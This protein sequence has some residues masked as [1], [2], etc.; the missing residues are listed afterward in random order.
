VTV[1]FRLHLP[2]LLPLL[3]GM[4]F[5]FLA[6]L[7]LPRAQAGLSREMASLQ[8]L[9]Q[10]LQQKPLK[11]LS[12]ASLWQAA[13][14]GMLA[15][16][17]DPYS[18]YLN[19]QE[20][21]EIK[22]LKTGEVAGIGIE[23]G[24]Q[25]GKLKVISALDHSPAW[26]AGLQAGDLIRKIEAKS[27]AQLS[28][29]ESLQLLQGEVQT[30]VQLEIERPPS[31]TPFSLRIQREILDLNPVRYQML[32]NQI[33]Y[34]RLNSF[35]SDQ[36]PES[37]QTALT[38]LDEADM[39]ALILDLRNNP[40]GTL[41]NAIEVCSLFLPQGNVVRVVDRENQET[42]H[43]VTGLPLLD[44]GKEL[45]L[46][47]NQ[48]TASA[49]E[50]VAGSLQEQGRAVLLGQ[51]TFGKGLVQ[52]LQSLS[53]DSGLSLTTSKYLTAFG[54]AVHGKGIEPDLEVELQTGV[55]QGS[56]QD[57]QLQSALAFVQEAL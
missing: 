1:K 27:T 39:R 54:Q 10:I 56:E 17:G 13:T 50:I 37:M 43:T 20:Y 35:F 51:R 12:E 21:T 33:G 47:V 26:K 8:E 18:Y 34:I 24:V 38:A 15:S 30:W 11:A 19:V 14:R 49:A 3:A 55:Q 9:A 53:D 23:V 45:V 7:N 46:L 28:F 2:F 32:P 44:S 5:A 41:S 29:A 31:H 57:T 40:G 36:V 4:L 25:N 16:L 42:L 48:G 22:Q 52:S 6:G